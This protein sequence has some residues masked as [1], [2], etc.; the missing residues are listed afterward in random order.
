MWELDHKEGWALKDWYFQAAVL[1]KTFERPFNSKEIK[2]V[3]PE[4]NQPWMFTGSIFV[5]AP[6]LWS[7]VVRANSLEKT[8]M[9]GKIKEEKEMI[10]DEMAG[11]H[12]WLNGDEFE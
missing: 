4:G 5:E 3:N 10:E 1:E 12:H 2:P 8:L 9:L 6:I 7:P 11:W